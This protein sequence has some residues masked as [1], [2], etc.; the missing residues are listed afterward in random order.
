[1]TQP[2]NFLVN[3]LLTISR[4]ADHFYSMVN[5]LEGREALYSNPGIALRSWV[6]STCLRKHIQPISEQSVLDLIVECNEFN[7]DNKIKVIIMEM[8]IQSSADLF[9]EISILPTNLHEKFYTDNNTMLMNLNAWM[10]DTKGSLDSGAEHGEQ[11]LFDLKELIDLLTYE[12]S[13]VPTQP[14]RGAA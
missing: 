13:L 4:R 6:V 1:M 11:K 7:Q 9:D 10:L 5:G 14:T 2:Q 8:L 3:D 12:L